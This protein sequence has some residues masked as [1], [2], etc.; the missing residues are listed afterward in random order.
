[1]INQIYRIFNEGRAGSALQ[2]KRRARRP[3]YFGEPGWIDT[4][5][6]QDVP[7]SGVSDCTGFYFH[8]F[9]LQEGVRRDLVRCRLNVWINSQKVGNQ[10]KV[11]FHKTIEFN[12]LGH[13]Q[14]RV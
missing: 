9:L 13:R 4:K 3:R 10:D 1:M 5:T 7:G 8:I 2:R 14:V 11:M 12:A 6:H